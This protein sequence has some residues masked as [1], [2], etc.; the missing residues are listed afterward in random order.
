MPIESGLYCQYCVDA[1]GKLQPFEERF[2]KMVDWQL[3][4]NP[5]A[6]RAQAEQDT[7]AFM[8]RMPAWKNDPGLKERL[9]R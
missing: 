4:R 7:L 3:K 9:G 8:S 6:G 2:T 1:N 5:A